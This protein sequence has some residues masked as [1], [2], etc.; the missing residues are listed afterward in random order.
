MSAAA[1]GAQNHARVLL[2]EWLLANREQLVVAI[3]TD[4]EAARA[5]L[6]QLCTQHAMVAGAITLIMHGTPEM[7][8]KAISNFDHELAVDLSLL[9]PDVERLQAA[10]KAATAADE[11]AAD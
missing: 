9:L 5:M 4:T 11:L 1:R 8:V 3:Q 2:Q 7:A 10:W 6:W